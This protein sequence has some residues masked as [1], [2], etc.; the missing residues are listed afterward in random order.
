M[1]TVTYVL[2]L[3]ALTAA[4]AVKP[5]YQYVSLRYHDDDGTARDA[6]KKLG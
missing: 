1:N 4:I 6:A 2:V 3:F 5:K